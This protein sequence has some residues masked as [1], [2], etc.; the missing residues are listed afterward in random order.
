M[1]NSLYNPA[2]FLILLKKHKAGLF[3]CQE[4][5]EKYFLLFI[6]LLKGLPFASRRPW[7]MRIQ[8]FQGRQKSGASAFH[9]LSS[10]KGFDP[11][12]D[13][14]GFFFD[15]EMDFVPVGGPNSVGGSS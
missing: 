5:K 4:N 15:R 1:Y 13:L 10:A 2:P 12:G 11:L 3:S 9:Q 6:S 8:G 14:E 7:G